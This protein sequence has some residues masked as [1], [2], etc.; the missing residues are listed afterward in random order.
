[1]N[2]ILW[3]LQ[4]LLGLLFLFAGGTKLVMSGEAL[5]QQMASTNSVMLPIWF[6]R[7]IGVVEVLGGLGLILP[8]LA[9]IRRS[10]TPLA[11]VGLTIIMIGAVV[12]T[13]MGPGVGMVIVPL[14]VLILCA[15]VAYGRRD[16]T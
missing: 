10:L 1:M 3:I 2:I 15:L 4:I 13:V 14:V 7:F 8:G 5:T 12:L 11:A 9:K 6:L 16:W